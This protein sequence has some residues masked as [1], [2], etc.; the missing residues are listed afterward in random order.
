MEDIINPAWVKKRRAEEY[1]TA[2]AGFSPTTAR[3][4]TTEEI[5]LRSEDGNGYKCKFV[6]LPD[7][8]KEWII[9]AINGLGAAKSAAFGASQGTITFNNWQKEVTYQFKNGKYELKQN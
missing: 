3:E 5:S 4:W 9:S 8:E 7:G 2:I 1:K 6:D